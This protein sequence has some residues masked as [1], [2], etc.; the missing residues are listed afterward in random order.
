M[1]WCIISDSARKNFERE[2]VIFLRTS[3]ETKLAVKK[4]KNPVKVNVHQFD[5]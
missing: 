5:I 1:K 2:S 3:N 4:K